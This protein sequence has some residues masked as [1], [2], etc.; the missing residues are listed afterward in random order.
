MP[1]KGSHLT[2]EQKEHLRLINTGKK[3]T[4]ESKRKMSETRKG[5]Q[6]PWFTN[7]GHKHTEES[8]EKIRI[9]HLG[10]PGTMLGRHLTPEQIEKARQFHLGRTLLLRLNLLH[11]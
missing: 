2:E 6:I 9:G 4:D 11:P 7:K 10:K 5:K 3:H 8:K 1:A